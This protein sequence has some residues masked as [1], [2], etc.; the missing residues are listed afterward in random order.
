MRPDRKAS[1]IGVVE[2]RDY[3]LQPGATPAFARYFEEHF[4]A[5]QREAGMHVLGQFAVADAPDRFVWLRGFE[6]MA[7]R[8]RGL[9]AFYGGPVWQAHRDTANGMMRESHHVHLL[10]PL[11][12]VETLTGGRVLEDRA[13]EPPGTFPLPGGLVAADLYRSRAGCLARLIELFERRLRPA[14]VARGHRVLGHFVTEL[15]PNDYP[16]LPVIQ[17]PD[18]LV[19]LTAYRDEAHH[20]AA[21]PAWTE[22]DAGGEAAAELRGLLAADVATRRLRPTARSLVRWRDPTT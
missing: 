12:P 18:L 14:L 19:V 1:A 15:A 16:R 8:L 22:G 4:L 17:D 5:S 10:R 21:R 9:T 7:S 3:L 20:A 6:S 13:G 11:G 2:L